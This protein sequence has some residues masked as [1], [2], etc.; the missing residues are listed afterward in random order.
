MVLPELDN[1]ESAISQLAAALKVLDSAYPK[2]A[3]LVVQSIH[4][5]CLDSHTG[6]FFL[7]EL[8]ECTDVARAEIELAIKQRQVC[9]GSDR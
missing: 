4:D 1:V 9:A 3:A 6:I 5:R 8:K 2:S 7:P